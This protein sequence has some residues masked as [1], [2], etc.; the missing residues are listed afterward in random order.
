MLTLNKNLFF[1]LVL[2][3]SMLPACGKSNLSSDGG[4]TSSS[5]ATLPVGSSQDIFGQCAATGGTSISS[6]NQ[7]LCEYNYGISSSMSQTYN[8]QIQFV[9]SYQYYTTG[10]VVNAGD[11]LKIQNS[12]NALQGSVGY[13][14]FPVNSGNSTNL[15]SQSGALTLIVTIPAGISSTSFHV[16]SIQRLRCINSANQAVQCP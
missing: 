14:G 12:G 3:A 7:Q 15:M 6:N 9:Q 10:I 1:S 8:L 16:S 4:S 2:I 5:V 13:G 11:T